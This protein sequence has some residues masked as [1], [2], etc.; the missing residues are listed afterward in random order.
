MA[1]ARWGCWD[2][3]FHPN[4]FP[5]RMLSFY[6]PLEINF[7]KGAPSGG[8]EASSFLEGPPSGMAS[9]GAC[10]QEHTEERLP[11]WSSG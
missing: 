4:L 7:S 8:L 1:G 11:W 2:Q 5:A 3:G 6:V 10:V 9:I